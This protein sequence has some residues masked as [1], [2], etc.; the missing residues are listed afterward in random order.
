MEHNKS[1]G[2]QDPHPISIFTC[3]AQF[4]GE[5]MMYQTIKW[6][7]IMVGCKSKEAKTF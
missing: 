4:N 1:I 2:A 3:D 6:T 5:G 7:L